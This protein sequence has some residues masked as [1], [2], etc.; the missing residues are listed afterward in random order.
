MN[1]ELMIKIKKPKNNKMHHS[2]QR[3]I[4]AREEKYKTREAHLVEKTLIF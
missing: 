2:L 4:A 3:L 1:N